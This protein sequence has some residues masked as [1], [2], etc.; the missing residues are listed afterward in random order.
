[1]I[2]HTVLLRNKITYPEILSRQIV[3]FLKQHTKFEPNKLI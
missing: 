2:L 1:M 3:G